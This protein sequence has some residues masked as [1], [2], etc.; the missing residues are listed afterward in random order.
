MESELKQSI[1][2]I[3]LMSNI[4]SLYFL[5]RG[6]LYR[7]IIKMTDE[8]MFYGDIQFQKMVEYFTSI[9]LIP[10]KKMSK[11]ERNNWSKYWYINIIIGLLISVMLIIIYEYI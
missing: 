11:N 10:D 2:T 9:G 4:I 7:V 3:L 6:I 8:D 1:R 5:L